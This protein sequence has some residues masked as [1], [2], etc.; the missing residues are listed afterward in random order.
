[1]V[2]PSVN[3]LHYPCYMCDMEEDIEFDAPIVLK[4]KIY[5]PGTVKVKVNCDKKF[6]VEG[7]NDVFDIGIIEK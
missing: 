3:I 2:E 6:S 1:M 4:L 7:E 5:K